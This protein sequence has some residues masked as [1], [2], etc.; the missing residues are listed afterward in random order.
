[1][2]NKT[3]D[4][5]KMK[6]S[7]KRK[8]RAILCVVGILGLSFLAYKSMV[9]IDKTVKEI[10]SI[11]LGSNK[12]FTNENRSSTKEHSD[13]KNETGQAGKRVDKNSWELILTNP[14]NF[15]PQGFKVELMQLSNGH[16]V[17]K[18]IYEDLQNM[19]DDARNQ[20]LSPT[21]CSSYRTEDFQRQLFNQEVD[22]YLNQ[23]LSKEEA[24]KKAAQWVAVPGT[25]EHQT[26]LAID[27]TSTNYQVLDK[28]QENT[29]EQKWLMENS[30]KYGFILRYPEGKTEITGIQY[31]PWHYRYVGKEA[32]KEIKE[33]GITLEEYLK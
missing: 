16:Q 22:T 1:M 21:I 13:E 2:K 18:R 24:K 20:G 8:K 4:Y 26:G 25:S 15:L 17:D 30:Y 29:P 11:G 27:I 12:S 23:G 7:R 6:K 28:Q 31:E 9:D 5:I 19:M 3:K 14:N 32:A 10:N 33:K